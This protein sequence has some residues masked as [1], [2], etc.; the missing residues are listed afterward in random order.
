MK[1]KQAQKLANK[2][3]R[4]FTFRGPLSSSPVV[5]P[6]TTTTPVDA[7]PPAKE[8]NLEYYPSSTLSTTLRAA[9]F[10]LVKTNMKA[11]YDATDGWNDKA[12]RR[13]MAKSTMRY[14]IVRDQSS[15]NVAAFTMF[16][17]SIEEA[18]EDDSW[19][20]V[21]Y[22]YEV[23]VRAG[24]QGHGLGRWLMNELVAIAQE[25]G[26]AKVMLTVFKINTAALQFYSKL[27]FDIDEISPSKWGNPDATYELLSIATSRVPSTVQPSR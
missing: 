21:L 3:N 5:P 19:V 17:F 15:E 24:S 26:M 2:A 1:E 8:W 22:C 13:E 4:E 7:D 16:D 14:L 20:P 10:D 11:L 18:E 12:K 23:Q 25:V 9:C 6:S 27:G